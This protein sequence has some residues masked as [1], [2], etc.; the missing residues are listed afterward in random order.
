MFIF[1]EIVL[2]QSEYHFQFGYYSK[3]VSKIRAKR[4]RFN[5]LTEAKVW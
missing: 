3:D 4:T 5:L 1:Y 2:A